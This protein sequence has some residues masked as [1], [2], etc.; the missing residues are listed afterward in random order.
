MTLELDFMNSAR[1]VRKMPEKGIHT[2][3]VLSTYVTAACLFT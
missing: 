2:A 3:A 1:F